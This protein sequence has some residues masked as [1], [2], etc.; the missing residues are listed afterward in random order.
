MIFVY[1]CCVIV[2]MLMSMLLC[3]CAF[4]ARLMCPYFP[5][6]LVSTLLSHCSAPLRAL[7]I[8]TDPRVTFG[9]AGE[10][11]NRRTCAVS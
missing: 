11:G 9:Y 1:V 3:M 6:G 5:S 7:S 2:H 4:P 8:S 10:F